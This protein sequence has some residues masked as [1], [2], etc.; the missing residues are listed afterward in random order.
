MICGTAK[1]CQE[2]WIDTYKKL[3]EI[4]DERAAKLLY[5]LSALDYSQPVAEN[6]QKISNLLQL[7]YKRE[8]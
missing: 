6:K 2:L 4:R 5:F 3:M 7:L 1:N 8:K